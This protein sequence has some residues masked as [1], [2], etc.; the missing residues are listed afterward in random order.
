VIFRRTV[1]LRGRPDSGYESRKPFRN[2]EQLDTPSAGRVRLLGA[3]ITD[4][5]RIG[6][7]LAMFMYGTVKRENRIRSLA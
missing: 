1:I 3:G 4:Q 7:L 2:R 5:Q 6:R